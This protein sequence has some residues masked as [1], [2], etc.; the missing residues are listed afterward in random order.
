M[1]TGVLS[2]PI[3]TQFFHKIPCFERTS[4]ILVKIPSAADEDDIHNMSCLE[5]C[6]DD[7]ASFV[8]KVIGFIFS[9]PVSL[10]PSI[11]VAT[12]HFSCI[13]QDAAEKKV[14]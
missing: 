11:H 5:L 3:P 9:I 2:T 6:F 7:A 8:A 14:Q 4:S 10:D 12:A 13:Q 1:L